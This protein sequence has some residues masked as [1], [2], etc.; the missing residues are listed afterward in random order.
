[1]YISFHMALETLEIAS[2]R[3]AT[4]MSYNCIHDEKREMVSLSSL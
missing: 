2:M 3:E 1:M 4:F